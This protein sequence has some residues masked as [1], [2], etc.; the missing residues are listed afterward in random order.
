[1]KY[2][3]RIEKALKINLNKVKK[4]E[5][6]IDINN[7]LKITN[8]NTKK[9]PAGSLKIKEL[10]FSYT[11]FSFKIESFFFRLG[12]RYFFNKKYAM[13]YL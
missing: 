7:K 1:M 6:Y 10:I 9:Y 11:V 2:K 12:Y 8:A 13:K 3:L 5:N 4:N